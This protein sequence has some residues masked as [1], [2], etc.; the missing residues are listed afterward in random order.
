VKKPRLFYYDEGYGAWVPAPEK[1]ENL[2][3]A[4][5][6]FGEDGE[7][8]KITF[9]RIDMTDGEMAILPEA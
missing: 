6:D 1:V 5:Q 9:R 2:I 7:E 8:V 3:I 4:D